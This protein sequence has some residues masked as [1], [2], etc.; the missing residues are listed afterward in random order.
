M[1]RL[2]ACT[3]QGTK[4]PAAP[5]LRASRGMFFPVSVRYTD[6]TITKKARAHQ[7]EY[8][9]TKR[10]ERGDFVEGVMRQPDVPMRSRNVRPTHFFSLRIP[11]NSH[12]MTQVATVHSDVGDFHA[13]YMKQMIPTTKLHVTASVAAIRSPEDVAKVVDIAR[14]VVADQHLNAPLRLFSRGMGHF[15]GGRVI[16]TRIAPERDCGKLNTL[17]QDLRL[18]LGEADG[19]GI[20]LLGNHNDTYVPHVTLGKFRAGQTGGVGLHKNAFPRE[21]WAPFQFEDFGEF[22]VPTLDLCEM[23]TDEATGY[24]KVVE[25]I[26]L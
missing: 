4:A 6:N 24:Y 5:W 23:A 22:A 26:E 11:K 3:L 19:V 18:A 21:V 12:F 16:F 14:S 9:R 1:F 20:D 7:T 10:H 15:G 25:S 8:Q 17:V 13:D 2:T